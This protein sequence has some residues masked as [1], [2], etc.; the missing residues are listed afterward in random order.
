[1]GFEHGTLYNPFDSQSLLEYRG[2]AKGWLMWKQ[3]KAGGLE[4]AL[5]PPMGP[6]QSPG[7][8]PGGEARGSCRVLSILTL[9]FECP[10]KEIYIKII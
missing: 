4:A 6:W 8:G 10:Y 3:I 9:N 2:V 7:G 1:M 5:R